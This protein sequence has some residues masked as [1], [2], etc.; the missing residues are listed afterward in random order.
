MPFSWSAWAAK[1]VLRDDS[2]PPTLTTM[3]LLCGATLRFSTISAGP[4]STVPLIRSSGSADSLGGVARCRSSASSVCGF[5][6]F[7][8]ITPFQLLIHIALQKK[9]RTKNQEPR[10]KNKG[11][12]TETKLQIPTPNP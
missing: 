10:T 4:P 8:M 6:C 2:S 3:P 1:A 11:T 7:M 5:F 12:K 9:S